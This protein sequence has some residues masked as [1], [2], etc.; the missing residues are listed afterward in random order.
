MPLNK[1][2]AAAAWPWSHGGAAAAIQ[3]LQPEI[4]SK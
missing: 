3:M 1:L 2:C 4:V